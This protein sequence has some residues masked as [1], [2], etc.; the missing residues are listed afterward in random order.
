MLN[1]VAPRRHLAWESC[2]NVRELGGY[3]TEDGGETRWGAFLRA[4]TLCRLTPMG[5]E[6]LVAYGIR[7]IIDLRNPAELA[8]APHPFAGRNGHVDPPVYVNLP[9]DNAEGKE[10]Y[11]AMDS[12]LT[13]GDIY[14]IMLDRFR[15]RIA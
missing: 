10:A 8:L 5:E 7:T 2:Y 11:E 1:K 4:D 6:A 14:V 3:P 12:A 13:M 15:G 9:L